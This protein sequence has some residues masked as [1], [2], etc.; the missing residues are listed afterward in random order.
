MKFFHL[1]IIIAFLAYFYLLDAI[2]ANV[3]PITLN[4][5]I[6]ASTQIAMGK[7]VQ[8]YSFWD[9]HHSNIY[10]AHLIEVS[11]YLKNNSNKQYIELITL[12]GIVEDEAQ[13]VY[14]NLDLQ[15]TQN[16]LFFLA[17][18]PPNLLSKNTTQIPRFCAY[19]HTQ[20]A[21][22]LVD[23][24]Y[25]DFIQQ[26]AIA[27][28]DLL[29]RTQEITQFSAVQPNGSLYKFEKT[30]TTITLKKGRNSI[31]LTN[32]LGE[33]TPLFYAGTANEHQEL[34]ISGSGFGSTAGI[35][36]F[37]NADT[38]GIGYISSDY[39]SDL[40]YWTDSEIRL[41]I[42]AKSGAGQLRILHSDGH[43]VGNSPILI[44]WSLN[45]VFSTY[46][47]FDKKTRQNLSFINANENGGYTIEVNSTTGFLADTLALAG[48]ERAL[49]KWQCNTTTNFQLNKTGTTQ[50]FA[51]DGIC[52]VQYTSDLPFGVLGIASSR[53]KSAGSTSCSEFNTL[54]YLK[55]FDIQ[56]KPNAALENGFSWNFSTD[57]PMH[58]Q[59]DF[60]SIALHELGH[61]H[62]LGHVIDAENIM[63]Y[64]VP[65]QAIKRNVS[66]PQI[67]AIQQKLTFSAAQTCISSYTP[68]EPLEKDCPLN[69][70]SARINL[71]LEGSYNET[72]GAMT[73]YL[74]DEGILPKTQPFT[75]APYFHTG[76]ES[77]ETF[78]QGVVD[79]VLLQ[80]RDPQNLSTILTKKALFLKKDGQLIEVNG[81]PIITLDSLENADYHIA[82]FHKSHLPIVSTIP[83]PFD[84]TAPL[85]DFTQS[86]T[87]AR[88][89]GQLK[90][91]NNVSMM[92]S[93]DFDG[94]GIIDSQDFNLWKQHSSA[95]N[96]YLSVDAD[97]NGII[98][99][100]DFNLWKAN[101]SK[102]SV[103]TSTK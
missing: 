48:F 85:Y 1:K 82:I 60:E 70:T 67:E 59:Y 56:F 84:S 76:S 19:T 42:P 15:L 18:L 62:G 65:S 102:I 26:R 22:P 31:T 21:L 20:G 63:H 41:K 24:K 55:E 90:T 49:T 5:R 88:G 35:V 33:T 30:S 71:F 53:Y 73:T 68:M 29:R 14:P 32:G 12:G 4:Q 86:A 28:T 23:N 43:L 95:I 2:N 9:K 54:W 27:A 25:E 47:G 6:E 83:H 61:A 7:I 34:I 46:R 72:Q 10:T 69:H 78:P 87:A 50:T 98:N 75:D 36:E 51:N 39:E 13:V 101:R 40:V 45:P 96:V 17:P 100:Q 89:T 66:P 37:P 57:S 64:S 44:E 77:V 97:G 94:N 93:G 3:Y 80:I 74:V 16:Y 92:N 11:A 91:K 8:Q 103:I 79:W 99:N 38:G 81:D 58:K 52:V